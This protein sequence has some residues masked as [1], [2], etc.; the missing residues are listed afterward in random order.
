MHPNEPSIEELEKEYRGLIAAPSTN[1]NMRKLLALEK[2]IKRASVL[3]AA[4]KAAPKEAP[5]EAPTSP[6]EA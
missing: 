3:G 4:P 2:Q 5:K 1:D 6:K